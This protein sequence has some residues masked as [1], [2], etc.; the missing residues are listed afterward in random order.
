MSVRVRDAAAGDEIAWRE[1]FTAYGRF[2]KSEFGPAVLDRVWGLVMSGDEQLR[3]LV[4]E[5]DGEVV[6]MAHYRVHPDTFSL[7]DEWYL[8]DLFTA[9]ATRGHGVASALIEELKA[10]KPEASTLRWITA[11]DNL[12]AQ[13]VYDRV[14]TKTTWVTYEVRG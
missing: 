3:L 4:A 5:I 1:L 9:P 7:G 8:E 10:R 12:T 6:G 13:R 2:Y 14:A 11:A